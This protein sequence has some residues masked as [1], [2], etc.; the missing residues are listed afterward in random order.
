M[1]KGFAQCK[2]AWQILFTVYELSNQSW[3]DF[4]LLSIIRMSVD[5]EVQA[6]AFLFFAHT[7]I[8]TPGLP[9]PLRETHL[10]RKLYSDTRLPLLLRILYPSSFLLLL[11]PATSS[12]QQEGVL[13]VLVVVLR[14]PPP[15]VSPFIISM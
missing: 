6:A 7:L 11:H 8:P 2:I 12:Q 4:C 9:L 15:E 10:S 3:G 5:L 14:S 1:I 13:F